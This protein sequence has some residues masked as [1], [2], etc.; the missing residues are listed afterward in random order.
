[1]KKNVRFL[2]CFISL[3]KLT[4]CSG[5]PESVKYAVQTVTEDYTYETKHFDTKVI[6]PSEDTFSITLES[7]V[8][9]LCKGML[10][11]TKPTHHF[12]GSS[13][14]IKEI[15]PGTFENQNIDSQLL[16]PYNSLTVIRRGTFRNMII[17]QLDL[18]YNKI[19]TIEKGALQHL[20]LLSILNLGRNRIKEFHPN[21]IVSTPKLLFFDMSLNKLEK[22]EENHFSFMSKERN[23]GIGLAENK[24]REIHPKAFK[25]IDVFTLNLTGNHLSAI[26]KE[27]FANN[28]LSYLAIAYNDLT[29]LDQEFFD[30]NT[31]ILR[32]VQ[33]EGNH[34]N[35]KTLKKLKPFMKIIEENRRQD[36]RYHQFD[37]T[38]HYR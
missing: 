10:N 2:L 30:M 19:T 6:S 14:G 8:P 32:D 23:V 36:Q 31:T 22:L 3:V 24:L 15:E 29:H 25:G 18:T 21:S 16:L 37:D 17:T 7:D 26:P 4:E 34:F 5:C 28:K 13:S 27:V 9:I 12:Y 1:M 11:I 20:P 38:V 33:L 35:K